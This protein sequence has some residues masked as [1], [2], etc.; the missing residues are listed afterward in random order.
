ML[1]LA[2]DIAKSGIGFAARDTGV[3]SRNVVSANNPDASTKMLHGEWRPNGGVAASGVTRAVDMALFERSLNLASVEAAQTAVL[4]GVTR[5]SEQIGDPADMRSP[6]ARLAEFKD[7][8]QIYASEPYE[9]R[10]AAG[11]V[12]SAVE[13]ANA[14]MGASATV[15]DERRGVDQ[16]I[17]L[18]VEALNSRLSEFE[19]LNRS[20][21]TGTLAGRDVTDWMDDR[22]AL[23]REIAEIVDIR[24]IARANNDVVLTTQSGLVLFEKVPRDVSFDPSGNLTGYQAGNSV[25]IDGVPV[26]VQEAPANPGGQLGGLLRVRDV[27]FTIFQRQL[28]ELA[29]GVIQAFAETDVATAGALPPVAGLFTHAGGPGLP[30]SNEGLALSLEVADAYNLE[31]GGDPRLLRD[32]GA[33]G[34]SYVANTSGA[35]GYGE[36]L[37]ALIDAISEPRTFDAAA[38]IEPNGSIEEFATASAAWVEARR[39]A[40]TSDAEMAATALQRTREAWHNVVGINLDD[41]LATLISLEQSYQASSRLLSVVDRLFDTLFAATD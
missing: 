26:T 31:A 41:Q 40:A 34:P 24:Q 14:L 11:A 15:L 29:N 17:A 4:A 9:Q 6:A 35:S 21:V 20:I 32:G 28:D 5:L 1:S 36:R 33:G 8:L 23:I 3:V 16:E 27:E 10:L 37:L 2:H 22:D 25:L 18:A 19:Q 12:Q 38:A 7:R 30:V 39:A 13:F